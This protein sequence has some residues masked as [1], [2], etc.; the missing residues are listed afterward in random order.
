MLLQLSFWLLLVLRVQSFYA[1]QNARYEVRV[2]TPRTPSYKFC[3]DHGK[4]HTVQVI[5][6]K[7]DFLLLSIHLWKR[8]S[9]NKSASSGQLLSTQ[10]DPEKLI[11]KQIVYVLQARRLLVKFS[12][13]D[14]DIIAMDET[15]VW[16]DMLPIQLLIPSATTR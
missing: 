2:N 3:H 12:Y 10:K 4:S 9:K 13:S 6:A 5:W 14:S 8:H 16:E 15:A 7:E 11:D 1:N